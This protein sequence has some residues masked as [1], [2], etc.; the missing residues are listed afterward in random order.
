VGYNGSK[1]YMDIFIWADIVAIA[2]NPANLVNK[3]GLLMEFQ[4]HVENIDPFAQELSDA[5]KKLIQIEMRRQML[6]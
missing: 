1:D 4:R 6:I 3:L 2:K 5:M